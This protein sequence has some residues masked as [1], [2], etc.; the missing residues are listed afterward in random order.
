VPA[1]AAKRKPKLPLILG[2]IGAF[3]LVMCGAGVACTAMV[4]N[5]V[6]KQTSTDAN[7]NPGDNTGASP[8]KGQ[9]ASNKTFDLAAG[10]TVTV[11]DSNGSWTL[12]LSNP[13]WKSKACNSL[14]IKPDNGFYLIVDVEFVVKTGTASIN[15]F[16]FEFHD[17]DGVGSDYDGFSGCDKPSLDSGNDIRAGGKRTGK[18][19]FDAT[20]KTGT[21]EYTPGF[22]GAEASWK[23]PAA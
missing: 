14:G 23:V 10:T 6:D 17:G 3:F 2:L 20:G 22:G 19:S 5:E 13:V 1:P 4:A 11:S 7:V 9:Q 8:T 21:I 18:V 16:D 12:R 15:P